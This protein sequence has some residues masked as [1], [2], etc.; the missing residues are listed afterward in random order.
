MRAAPANGA[1]GRPANGPV[2][3]GRHVLI[4]LPHSDDVDDDIQRMQRLHALFKA[5]RGPDRLAL[6]VRNGRIVTRLEPLERVAYSD[7]FRQQVEGLLGAG[8]VQLRDAD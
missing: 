7:D 4:S 1:A 2:E 5:H 3:D 6:L 8:S